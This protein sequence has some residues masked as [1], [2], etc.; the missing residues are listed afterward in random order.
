MPRLIRRKAVEAMTGLHRAHIYALMKQGEFPQAV[1]LAGRAVAWIED[2]VAAWIDDRIKQ[3]RP[4]YSACGKS[5][6]M[7]DTTKIE[8]AL[9]RDK[10][11]KLSDGKGA[12]VL[13]DPC[14]GKYFRFDYRFQGKR[15]TLALGVYPDV[16]LMISRDRVRKAREMLACGIDPKL[17]IDSIKQQVAPVNE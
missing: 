15:K 1:P 13:V 8:S 2:E 14:G 11:Y 9:P 5:S 16:T 6:Q 17:H 3:A 12:Y 7:L 4:G 10:P